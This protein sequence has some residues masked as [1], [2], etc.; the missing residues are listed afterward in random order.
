[1]PFQLIPEGEKVLK[2]VQLVHVAVAFLG[3][4]K[5]ESEKMK[6]KNREIEQDSYYA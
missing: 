5:A 4:Q 3:W 6:V 2:N 1:M